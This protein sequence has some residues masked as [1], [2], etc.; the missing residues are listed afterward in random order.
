MMNKAYLF[1]VILFS[2][3][4]VTIGLGLSTF[5]NTEYINITGQSEEEIMEALNPTEPVQDSLPASGSSITEQAN[6]GSKLG[7]A[8][9]YQGYVTTKELLRNLMFGYQN[10]FILIGLS[11][12]LVIL[13]TGIIGIIQIGLLFYIA[14]QIISVI[15][16]LF[17]G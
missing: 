3:N 11:P 13:F 17:F 16:G 2:I 14:L 9:G 6:Q 4:I 8:E 15:R 10:I 1:L 12:L 7:W 5:S